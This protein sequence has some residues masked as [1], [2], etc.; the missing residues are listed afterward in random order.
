M[1]KVFWDI[2]EMKTHQGTPVYKIVGTAG[3]KDMPILRVKLCGM[4]SLIPT[5]CEEMSKEIQQQYLHNTGQEWN[6]I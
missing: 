1:I 5:M 2:T 4:L 3:S 6:A